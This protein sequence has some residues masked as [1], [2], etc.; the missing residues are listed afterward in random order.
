MDPVRA[1]RE[2]QQAL[3]GAV[4]EIAELR[5]AHERTIMHGVVTAR[6]KTKGVRLQI[7]LDA[8]GRPVETDWLP[9]SQTAGVRK[10]WSLPSVGQ[11]LTAFCPSGDAQRAVLMP[12]T[13]SDNNPAPSD[14]VDADVDLRGKTRVTQKDGSLK[15]E[16]DGVTE[17]I[18][19]QSHSVTLHKDEQAAA[20]VDDK[21]PW[22]GNTG[23]A[24]HGWTITKD[25]G[26]EAQ[27]NMG[28]AMHLFHIHPTGGL[29][30]S[31]FGGNHQITIGE[32]GIKHKSTSRV[33]VE[34]PQ[35][36]HNGALKV[37]GSILA[38]GVVQS[39]GFLGNLQGYSIGTGFGGGLSGAT[40]W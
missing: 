3:A 18:S 25:G 7:G 30:V 12:F 40:D 38:G 6:D 36:E 35:I 20:T 10:T 31:A 29:T 37:A 22:A 21:H 17:T 9:M 33:T 19:K 4:Q 1:I 39:A 16:V 24:L 15:R 2:L 23:D 26:L 11:Q 14:D 34:A 5:A 32:S 8:D 13:W 28:G 27:V